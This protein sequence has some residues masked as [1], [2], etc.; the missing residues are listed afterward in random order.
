MATYY[1]AVIFYGLI[2][3]IVAKF[4]FNQPFFKALQ[5]E[6]YLWVGITLVYYALFLMLLSGFQ[7]ISAL[8]DFI[9]YTIVYFAISIGR[10]F[11]FTESTDILAMMNQT[12]K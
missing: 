2:S 7:P 6:Y 9:I 3:A 1:A 8:L 4:Y 10:K 12:A 5:N 11:V